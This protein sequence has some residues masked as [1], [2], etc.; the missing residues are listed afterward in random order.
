MKISDL[1]RR[2]LPVACQLPVAICQLLIKVP[3]DTLIPPV[4]STKLP[5]ENQKAPVDIDSQLT[6]IPPVNRQ[7]ATGN[8]SRCGYSTPFP[9]KI[10]KKFLSCHKTMDM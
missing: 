8:V 9:R 3:V 1:L 4:A 7:L 6:L 5:V 2:Q 10:L